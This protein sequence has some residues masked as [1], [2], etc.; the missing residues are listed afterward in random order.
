MEYINTYRLNIFFPINLNIKPPKLK[1]A[2]YML[3]CLSKILVT[4]EMPMVFCGTLKLKQYMK[5]YFISFLEIY[6]I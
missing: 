2:E 5:Q 4:S 3:S 6:V 1:H